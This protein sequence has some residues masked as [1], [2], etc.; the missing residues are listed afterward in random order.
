M[1]APL[2][3][4][5]ERVYMTLGS[6]LMKY[7]ATGADQS[8]GLGYSW[9]VTYLGINTGLEFDAI[10]VGDFQFFLKGL[11]S[12]EFFLQG[13]QTINNDYYNLK[14]EQQF[15]G[16]KVFVRGGGGFNYTVKKDITA[17]GYYLIGGN[18]FNIGDD[19]SSGEK[20][21]ITSHNINIG[22]LFRL[23]NFAR[24]R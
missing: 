9:D 23:Q 6:T 10:E 12:G 13:T 22:V 18:Y 17:F 24:Y 8:L 14:G 15:D 16:L 5:G 7:G 1:K 11:V 19:K 3:R 2:V 4:N 21:V 20:L